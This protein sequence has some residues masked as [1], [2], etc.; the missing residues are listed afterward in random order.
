MEGQ[1]PG[2]GG[3]SVA[4]RLSTALDDLR[5]A[6][7]RSTDDARARIE[8]AIDQIREASNAA[9]SRAQESVGSATTR[10]QEAA[11]D[12]RAQLESFRGWVQGATADLLDE[13]QKEIDKRRQQLLG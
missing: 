8:S 3:G 2:T 6:A 13:I 9:A 11:G 5:A 12:A 7:E 10:A 4:D 1:T